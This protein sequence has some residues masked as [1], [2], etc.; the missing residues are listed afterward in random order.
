M[1]LF[2]LRRRDLNLLPPH[3]SRV[4]CR[5]LGDSARH[6]RALRRLAAQKRYLIVFACSQIIRPSALRARANN[7]GGRVCTR[8]VGSKK[9]SR[10]DA[11][12]FLF[13]LY[14][15]FRYHSEKVNKIK[16]FSAFG[17]ISCAS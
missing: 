5:R 15:Q 11:S 4:V 1:V 16:A 14:S 12:A 3:R 10:C 7:L 8:H 2:W 9:K 13:V 17:V 6:T